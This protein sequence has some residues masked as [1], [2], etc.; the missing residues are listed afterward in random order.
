MQKN[1]FTYKKAFFAGLV[2]AFVCPMIGAP[3]RL[4]L[5]GGFTGSGTDIVIF[6]LRAA[7]KEMVTAT[8][9]GAVVGN[10]I[11]KIISCLLVAWFISIPKFNRYVSVR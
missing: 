6:S 11:D 2:L 3:I 9:W 10:L 7:G 5:F 1:G 4:F 8:Y